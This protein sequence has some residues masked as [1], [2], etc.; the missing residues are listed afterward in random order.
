M[1][2]L[3]FILLV[4]FSFCQISGI[5]FEIAEKQK[6]LRELTEADLD[7]IRIELESRAGTGITTHPVPG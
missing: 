6:Y 3:I 4:R 2:K 5:S 7:I 1:K